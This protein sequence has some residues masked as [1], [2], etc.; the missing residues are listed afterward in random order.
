MCCLWAR[1]C[2]AVLGAAGPA[3]DWL[4]P[5][6]PLSSSSSYD[7]WPWLA[8]LFYVYNRPQD[9][10]HSSQGLFCCP[11]QPVA[12]CFVQIPA[13]PACAFL[14]TP[15][16]HARASSAMAE[17]PSQKKVT[18]SWVP[19]RRHPTLVKIMECNMKWWGFNSCAK[20]IKRW[21]LQGKIPS[22][23]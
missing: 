22:E 17:T 19:W 6:S 23:I 5:P 10:H 1:P 12:L 2:L 15:P 4:L 13:L 18:M 14:F 8:V 7:F 11:Q 3:G 16:L 9:S 21:I 20:C